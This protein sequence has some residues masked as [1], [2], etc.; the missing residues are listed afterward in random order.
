[1]RH[2]LCEIRAWSA[3]Y[4]ER[5]TK[6]HAMQQQQTEMMQYMHQIML[7]SGRYLMMLSRSSIARMI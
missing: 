2:I 5:D 6:I 1:M 3:I 7:L 4:A